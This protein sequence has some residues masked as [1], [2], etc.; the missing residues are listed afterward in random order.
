MTQLREA[1]GS[2][3]GARCQKCAQ[4]QDE[5][6][7]NLREKAD[8]KQEHIRLEKQVRVLQAQL[9]KAEAAAAS[10]QEAATKKALECEAKDAKLADLD[11]SVQVLMEE[12]ASRTI[13]IDQLRPQLDQSYKENQQIVSQLLSLKETMADR[14]NDINAMQQEAERIKRSAELM[15][16]ANALAHAAP[17]TPGRG[18]HAHGSAG[19]AGGAGGGE[20]EMVSGHMSG[21]GLSPAAHGHLSQTAFCA[22]AATDTCAFICTYL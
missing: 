17:T 9:A 14:Y 3:G 20:S 1:S 13:E 11:K 15:A 6:T 22:H 2:E 19:S 18:A 8:D 5:L 10:A 4:M 12:C 7:R 21:E 16:A